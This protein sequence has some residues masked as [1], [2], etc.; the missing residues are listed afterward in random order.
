MSRQERLA[1]QLERGFEAL[2][3]GR[4]DDAATVLARCR[5]AAPQDPD[6]LALAAALADARGEVEE[7]IASY[8]ELVA[9]CP[10]DAPPR[11]CL[12]R[13]QLHDR[14]DAE[15]ALET[16]AAAFDF[17]DEETDLVEAV[18]VQAEAMLVTGDVDG[19]RATLAELSTSVIEDGEL[20]LELGELALAAEDPTLAR[21]WAEVALADATGDG[22]ADGDAPEDAPDADDAMRADAL[23]LLG[24]IHEAAGDR[25][26][27][28]AAWQEVR[29][30]DAAAPAGPVTVAEEAL[31]NEARAT[32]EALPDE[33]R[34][35]L[36]RVPVLIDERPSVEQ[37]ADGLDPR[38]LG[39]FQGTPLPEGGDLAPTV[40]NIVLFRKNLERVA[41]DLDELADEVRITVL[42]ET[43]HYFGLDEDDLIELGLD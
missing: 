11:I 20:A 16:I 24:R 26:A 14:G 35:H 34:A 9:A 17:I 29:T 33:V 19:A 13:L 43:A 39:V 15:A 40:T 21:R 38:A 23:H 42:H 30:L 36:E 6:V 31:V 41:G 8:T 25:A 7:A 3:D 22:E 10:D 27:M 32:L 37:I 5:K 2:E 1:A 28:V 18:I 12:A 4:L